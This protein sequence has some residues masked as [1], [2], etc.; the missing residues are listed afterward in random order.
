MDDDRLTVW[1][2]YLTTPKK[3]SEAHTRTHP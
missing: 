1:G 3:W 2:D